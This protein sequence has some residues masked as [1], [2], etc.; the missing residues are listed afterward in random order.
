MSERLKK[1]SKKN[2]SK[3]FFLVVCIYLER[4]TKRWKFEYFFLERER[5]NR[6]RPCVSRA[7]WGRDI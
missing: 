7:R 2:R 3:V 1:N 4:E 5:E 6:K